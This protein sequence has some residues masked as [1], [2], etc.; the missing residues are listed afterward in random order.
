MIWTLEAELDGDINTRG[1]QEFSQ[2]E[3]ASQINLLSVRIIDGRPSYSDNAGGDGRH[4]GYFGNYILNLNTDDSQL[5]PES[6]SA[7]SLTIT[8][9]AFTAASRA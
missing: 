2:V 9:S 1:V 3:F 5:P 6:A 8:A 4:S 7:E